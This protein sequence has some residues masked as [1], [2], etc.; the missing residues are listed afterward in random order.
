M[1]LEM[2]DDNMKL[3]LQL[4]IDVYFT[5]TV[6]ARLAM[7]QWANNLGKFLFAFK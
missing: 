2:Y 7:K 6:K 3:N 1:S 4:F 5:S